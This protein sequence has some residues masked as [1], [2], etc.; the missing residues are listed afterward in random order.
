MLSGGFQEWRFS[1]VAKQIKMNVLSMSSE[2]WLLRSF[3]EW[4]QWVHNYWEGIKAR[5]ILRVFTTKNME[6]NVDC[7]NGNDWVQVSLK[8][9][10]CNHFTFIIT[11]HGKGKCYPGLSDSWS[12]TI[13][14]CVNKWKETRKEGI[15]SVLNEVLKKKVWVC[16]NHLIMKWKWMCNSCRFSPRLSTLSI[17][18]LY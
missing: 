8:I 1:I 6:G 17:E 16:V 9:S 14:R 2:W 3:W 13:I 15:A 18:K 12:T 11:I 10:S 5:N 4:T 7:Y